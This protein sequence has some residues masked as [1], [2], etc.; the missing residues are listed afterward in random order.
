MIS[1]ENFWAA[2]LRSKIPRSRGARSPDPLRSVGR[3]TWLW[4]TGRY[5]TLALVPKSS[6]FHS[7]LQVVAVLYFWNKKL[8]W[9]V[10]SALPSLP[11]ASQPQTSWLNHSWYGRWGKMGEPCPLGLV[12]GSAA[13]STWQHWC[14]A[15]SWIFLKP[16]LRIGVV[17]VVVVMVESWVWFGLRHKGEDK[18]KSK[19]QLHLS[20]LSR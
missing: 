13:A 15:S 11:T 12:L 5:Q 2:G 10:T 3:G 7:I 14:E 6:F 20:S 17:V 19:D 8:F 16:Y 1:I 4:L 18:K 9:T